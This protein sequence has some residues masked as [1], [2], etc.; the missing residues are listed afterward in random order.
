MYTDSKGIFWTGT[1]QGILYYDFFIDEFIRLNEG[2][3]N[4]QVNDIDQAVDGMLWISTDSG[5]AVLDPATKQTTWLTNITLLK[6]G[7]N[8]YIPDLDIKSLACEPDGKIWFVVSSGGLYQLDP[9]TGEANELVFSGNTGFSND[10]ILQIQYS[11]NYLFINTDKN[12]LYWFN[13]KSSQLFN[14]TF[15]MEGEKI[16][17]FQVTDDSIAWLAT[18]NGLIR[19]EYHGGNFR[20]YTE[21]PSNPFS[22]NRSGIVFVFADK[23]KNIWVSSGV[24]GISYGL[25]NVPFNHYS[26]GEV[27]FQLLQPEVTAITFDHEENM[28]LG[29]EEG[30]IEMHSFNRQ[31][32]ETYKPATGSGQNEAGAI[33]KI[34]QDSKQQIWYGG[35]NT[36]L[37][38]LNETGFTFSPVRFLPDSFNILLA[39]ADIR[40]IIEDD[41]GNLWIGFYGNGI[42]RYNP[43][44]HQMDL[45]RHD[46]EKPDNS[47]S[48]NWIN[49]LCRD[50]KN[51][52]W[53]ATSSGI[54]QLNPEKMEFKS[55]FHEE[56]NP[57]TLNS[58][59]VQTIY[60]DS[61]GIIWAGTSI[62]LNAYLPG[63]GTFQSVL[64]DENGSYLNVSAIQ[65]AKPEE[66]WVSTQTGIFS[67]N[68]TLDSD[69]ENI[70]T[71]TQFFNR[72]NGLISTT[73]FPRSTSINND[74]MIFFGGN[75]GIDYFDPGKVQSL[76]FPLSKP[77]LTEITVDGIPVFIRRNQSD[78]PLNLQLN[79]DHRMI[80]IRFANLLFSNPERQKFRYRM[81]GLTEQW[82]YPQNEQVATF[83]YL[84]PGNYTFELETQDK[85]GNW[86][87]EQVLLSFVV[88][89]PFWK[90]VPFYLLLALIIIASILL[91][92][93]TKSR[94]FLIRQKE[95][96]KIID[97][98]T[99]ELL[100][101]NAELEK[102]NQTKDKLFSII[103]HDLRSP[104]AGVLGILELL[105]DKE[106]EMEEHRK[107][108]L[109]V[110][111]K[112][113]AE[114]TFEL[115]ENLLTWAHSQMKKTVS[116][117]LKQNLAPVL[118][119]NVEL[120]RVSA[121]QKEIEIHKDFPEQLEAKFDFDM[122]N[123]VVRNLLNNAVKFTHPGGKIFV[124]AFR[125]QH[126][127]EIN[128]A[129]TGIGIDMED[130]T[131]LFYNDNISRKG[132]L[133]EKGTGLGLI[134]C[135]EFIEKN[136]GK[137]RAFPN[138]PKGTVFSF[139]LPAD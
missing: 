3:G 125:N 81:K 53:I 117:P 103:S 112:N 27:P 101:N 100:Y 102:I 130:A 17:H 40:S 84:P 79:H 80:S 111:A 109:L 44:T 87:G 72:S 6:T 123:T 92:I 39:E 11:G 116:K 55:F 136:Y 4:E 132:T 48:G 67:L 131:N 30:V 63:S 61:S 35:N 41:Q 137:I 59:L 75:E 122:V 7:D 74:G 47:L 43:A 28:W 115:L 99:R 83:S 86:N 71:E 24:K 58:N 54:S 64:S 20:R 45:F 138:Q 46:P 133:G 50:N 12:G 114:S 56:G 104:F 2:W 129:D 15:S 9:E 37:Q 76:N 65:S 14:E 110:M 36:G 52:I 94:V 69:Q 33:L 82:H 32:K 91:I 139:T 88:K 108:E 68:Y 60:C 78:M 19:F 18:N 57:N 134:I 127:V 90:T 121:Q 13:P 8:I 31:R 98:R 26:E 113:S 85:T 97:A 119:K 5:L 73:Y 106:T 118:N 107:Q 95:L 49:D 21:D 51:T 62:G 10:E 126:E 34:F 96:E 89:P 128:I 38:K 120:R 66:L 16:R 70:L 124:T 105:S 1:N 22:I 77:L 42:G 25:T 23:E 135:R 29:Y 93:Y